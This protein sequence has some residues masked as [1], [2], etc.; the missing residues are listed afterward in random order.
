MPPG[1]RSSPGTPSTPSS[2]SGPRSA[3][4][5]APE[6][7]GADRR[8]FLGRNGSVAAPRRA[9]RVRPRAAP[10]RRSTPARCCS[11]RWSSARASPPSWWSS[12]APPARAPR[13]SRWWTRSALVGRRRVERETVARWEERLSV[14]QVKTPE[15]DLRR[16]A[17]P[18]AALP[19]AVLPDV[20]PL[21]AL[22][23]RRGL[24]IPRPA[25]KIRWPSLYAEPALVRA[26][27]LRAAGRQFV[28]GD[29]QHWWHP[30]SGRGMRTRISDDLV[31][32]PVAVGPLPGGH[33]RC[34][35]AR[36]TRAL[37]EPAPAPAR[38]AR[39]LRATLCRPARRG[40]STSIAGGRSAGRRPTASHGLPLIGGGDWNDGMNRVGSRARARASGWGGSW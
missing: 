13:P 30:Q 22:P 5:P 20:G 4:G 6:R 16:P 31:W 1:A 3:H 25:C 10:A 33:R 12:S 8:E 34:L 23:E 35:G 18:L 40:R 29:V 26:H 28:E 24:R 37:P 2:R 32:L 21:R 9:G 36:G 17:Q 39:G 14:V 11:G 15:T 27:L 7:H 38:R 19:D